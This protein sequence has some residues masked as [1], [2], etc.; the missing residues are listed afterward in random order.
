LRLF[1]DTGPFIARYSRADLHHA[2]SVGTFEKI[3]RGETPYRKL[4]TSDYILDEAVTG[5]RQ[6]TRTHAASV[7]LGNAILSSRSILLLKVDDQALEESW[8]L[9]KE[10]SEV[11]I[12]FTDCTTAVLARRHGIIELYTYDDKD[13]Q[14]LG[15]HTISKL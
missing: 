11:Q 5:C 1:I 10:R 9:Y 15:F 6:R 3:G 14:P 2:D 12:S 13:F 8:E 4:Y 7:E